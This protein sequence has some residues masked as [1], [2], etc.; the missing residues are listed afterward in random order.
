[1]IDQRFGRGTVLQQ[2]INDQLPDLFS[3]AVVEH[4]LSPLG[5]P[6][7]DIVKLDDGEEVELA[8]QFDVR[9]EFDLPDVSGIAVTVPSAVIGD[10]A[11]D[12]RL[13]LLRTRFAEYN[14]L[15]RAAQ[16]GDVVNLDISASRDGGALSG[17]DATGMNYIVGAGGL[18]E[19]LDEA[20]TGLAAGES[21]TFT[22]QLVGG[23][24]A[25]ETADVTVTVNQVQQR[26]LPRVDDDFAQMV[27]E[28]DTAD[29]MR[30]GLRDSLERIERLGQLN[31]ARNQMLDALVD[32]TDFAVPE[33]VMSDEIAARHDDVENQLAGAGLSLDRYL[34]EAPDET[35]KTP[36]EF[37]DRLDA[38]AQKGL[39]ARLILD[40]V[41]D[42]QKIDVSQD[43]LAAFIL[44]KAE[45]DGVTPDQEA[46]HMMEHNHTVE[47]MSEIRRSKA[48]TSLVMQANAH[49]T[50]G[51]RVDLS[52][53]RPDGTLGEITS[54]ETGAKTAANPKA[55]AKAAKK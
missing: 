6:Q 24:H 37:W 48:M 34:A 5:A 53:I 39:K 25:G 11:V 9:P 32:A 3:A 15:D 54:A 40:K 7:I 33:Q 14:D 29:Q 49:D 1:M 17:T 31:S 10:E 2:A 22:T 19:G 16:A 55:K 45:D 51:R 50:D 18:V 8:A 21:K 47:W 41:A 44:A 35:A 42:D 27:S 23:E 28:Y 26:V 12:E 52:L 36:E 43:D 20:I 30:D 13:E 38:E 46:A 4:E